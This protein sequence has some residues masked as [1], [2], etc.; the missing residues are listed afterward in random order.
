MGCFRHYLQE[1]VCDLERRRRRSAKI[2]GEITVI[3][4]MH[5]LRGVHVKPGIIVRAF[6]SKHQFLHE[7]DRSSRPTIARSLRRALRDIGLSVDLLPPD[8]Q[9]LVRWLSSCSSVPLLK[10]VIARFS[11]PRL[12]YR[13]WDEAITERPHV[14]FRRVRI[15]EAKSFMR[16]GEPPESAARRA[17]LSRAEWIH[18]EETMRGRKKSRVGRH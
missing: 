16:R 2:G 11:S 9:L 7:H 17:G 6:T 14:F 12:F 13:R 8:L 3:A 1:A 4:P 18:R 5:I 15:Y 10:N